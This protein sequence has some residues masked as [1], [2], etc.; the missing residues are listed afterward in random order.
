MVRCR[1]IRPWLAALLLVPLLAGG[2]I[3]LPDAVG[4]A[5]AAGPDLNE[6]RFNQEATLLTSGKV[7]V[8]GGELGRSGAQHDCEVETRSAKRAGPHS[9]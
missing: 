9:T 8:A 7:L 2:L 5:L 4:G 6:P 1:L 3:R